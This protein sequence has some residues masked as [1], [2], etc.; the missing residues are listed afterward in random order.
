MKRFVYR[1]GKW[2]EAEETKPHK[3]YCDSEHCPVSDNC[4]RHI[5][6]LVVEDVRK[7]ITETFD[8]DNECLDYDPIE[9]I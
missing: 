2:K 9:D 4:F 5:S 3:T 1:N 6:N 8:L 7:I